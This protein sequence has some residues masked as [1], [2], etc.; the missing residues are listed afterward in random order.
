[1]SRKAIGILYMLGVVFEMLGG[2]ELLRNFSWWGRSPL[3]IVA[4][5]ILV[6][7]AIIMGFIAWIG[8]L[9]NLAK[10]QA[11]TMFTLAFFFSGIILLI[12]LFSDARTFAAKTA[13]PPQPWLAQPERTPSPSASYPSS[14]QSVIFKYGVIAGGMLQ[15]I[16][17]V[18]IVLNDLLTFGIARDLVLD[19]VIYLG[20]P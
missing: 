9:I 17:P 12:Y 14:Y 11:W 16:T 4:G 7:A 19:N 6:A 8:M 2:V 13:P 10:A 15:V 20:L 18:C 3:G 1:M 5:G